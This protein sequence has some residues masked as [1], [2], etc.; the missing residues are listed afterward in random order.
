MGWITPTAVVIGLLVQAPGIETLPAHRGGQDLVGRRFHKPEFD[1]WI[2]D[3]ARPH[4]VPKATLYRWWTDSCPYCR[5][6]L[7]AIETLRR[8]YGPKGLDVVGVYHPKPPRAV[9]DDDVR[10][11]ARQLGFNGRIAVDENWSAL[12]HAYLRTGDRRAT[13]VTFLV[14]ADGVI[15]FL[16][17]GPVFFPSDDAE[18]TVE[19]DDYRKLKN[20]IAIVLREQPREEPHEKEHSR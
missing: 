19:N 2:D 1:R 20:A 3:D 11:A 4:A 16:H 7:P 18:F 6:S 12:D 8:E 5:A 9:T 14:D 10:A 15:R 13:S 17:P